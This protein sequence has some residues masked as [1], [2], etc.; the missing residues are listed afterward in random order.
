MLTKLSSWIEFKGGLDS[1]SLKENCILP[2]RF[3]GEDDQETAQLL[4][5]NLVNRDKVSFKR[6]KELVMDNQ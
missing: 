6:I 5:T 3:G 1:I 2:S 4:L